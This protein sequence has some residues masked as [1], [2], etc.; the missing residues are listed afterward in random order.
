MAGN[1]EKL[2]GFFQETKERFRQEFRHRV[3]DYLDIPGHPSRLS[4]PDIL[5]HLNRGTIVIYPFEERNLGTVSYDV[6]LGENFYRFKEGSLFPRADGSKSVFFNPFSKRDIDEAIDGPHQAQE[7]KEVILERLELDSPGEFPHDYDY[8]FEM[9]RRG[10]TVEGTFPYEK[11]ITL[12]PGEMIL[13]HTNEVIG[14]RVMITT[15]ISGRSSLGR[16]MIEVCNDAF[17]GDVG[18]INRFTLEIRNKSR[19]YTLILP[20]N[21]RIA[22]VSFE[23]VTPVDFE[24]GERKYHASLNRTEEID[25]ER[26][27][28]EWKPEM[29]L[30]R[31]WTDWELQNRVEEELAFKEGLYERQKLIAEEELDES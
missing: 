23:L 31:T 20:V 15:I 5:E 17:V 22:Q 18:Y 13:G 19:K 30:P 21:K 6:T 14:G 7:L 25:L 8:L 26:I 3:L 29:M 9:G 2:A 11:V 1:P 24:H 4:R 16:G 10:W 12:S 28:Q 27:L